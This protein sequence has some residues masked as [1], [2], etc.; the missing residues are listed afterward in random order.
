V[1]APRTKR[2]TTLRAPCPYHIV[3]LEPHDDRG[4]W[5]PVVGLQIPEASEALI[6]RGF[7]EARLRRARMII[8]CDTREQAD[9]IAG[10]AG[11]VGRELPDHRRIA[12][13][14]AAAAGWGRAS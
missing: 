12:L 2:W 6:R 13:E 11:R 9:W 10:I 4:G 7:A 1:S 14:R 5:H 8:L 3:T